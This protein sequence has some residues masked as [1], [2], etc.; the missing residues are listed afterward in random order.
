LTAPVL[1]F[2]KMNAP[3]FMGEPHE[4]ENAVQR[5]AQAELLNADCKTGSESNCFKY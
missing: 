1:R 2:P 4:P 3:D 5:R